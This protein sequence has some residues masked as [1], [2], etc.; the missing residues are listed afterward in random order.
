MSTID[1][2][3]V[4]LLLSL[5]V[6]GVSLAVFATV[7]GVASAL[8]ADTAQDFDIDDG[9][10]VVTGSSGDEQVLIE[11]VSRVE[12]IEITTAGGQPV[13]QTAPR[14]QPT[15]D[16]SQRERAKEIVTSEASIADSV[17]TGGVLYSFRPI[18]A[19]VSSEQA[20]ILGAETERPWEFAS[21]TSDSWFVARENT[22]DGTLVFERPDREMSDQRVLTV[23]NVTESNV[24][25]SVVVDLESGTIASVVRLGS[26]G[27]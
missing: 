23:V 27:S 15:L 9:S 4:V 21:P 16:K 17:E 7:T 12:R 20:A 1:R 13:V 11:D 24:R 22:T 6:L 26:R 19:I 3:R 10:L 8:T 5:V 14:Q 25:Y 18:P 2:S